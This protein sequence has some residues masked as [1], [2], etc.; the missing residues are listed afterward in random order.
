M[1]NS[2]TG[3]QFCLLKSS[4]KPPGGLVYF[5]HT[6]EGGRAYLRGG[7]Y[8]ILAKT[9]VLVLRKELEYKVEKLRIINKSELPFG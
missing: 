6:W 9:M 4:I 2:L 7:A 8:F 3:K 5:K 1:L